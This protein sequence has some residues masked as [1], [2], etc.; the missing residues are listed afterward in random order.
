MESLGGNEKEQ[1]EIEVKFKDNLTLLK[2]DHF[3]Y[4]ADAIRRLLKSSHDKSLQSHFHYFVV[5]ILHKKV[6]YYVQFDN[7]YASNFQS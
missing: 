4:D 6:R 5:L 7:L 3:S 1:N 2:I